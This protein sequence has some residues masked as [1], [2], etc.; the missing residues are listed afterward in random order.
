VLVAQAIT[1]LHH[2]SLPVTSVTTFMW[3]WRAVALL[4]AQVLA[5][6]YDPLTTTEG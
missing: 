5:L 4:V 3:R 2:L 6:S 1:W